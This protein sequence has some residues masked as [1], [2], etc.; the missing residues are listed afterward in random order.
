M[1]GFLDGDPAGARGARA[2]C[3]PTDVARRERS[4]RL[5]ERI[6]AGELSPREAVEAYLER[7]EA[8][9]ELN[10]Y[11]SVRAEEALAEAD[12]APRTGRSTACPSRSRT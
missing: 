1:L 11:I 4:P 3:S 2:S 8:D 10:A 5:A 6:R 9:R 7:I 12:A